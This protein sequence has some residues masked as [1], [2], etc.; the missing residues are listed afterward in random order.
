ML[1]KT[2]QPPGNLIK[3]GC[4]GGGGVWKKQGK[5]KRSGKPGNSKESGANMGEIMLEIH[6]SKTKAEMHEIVTW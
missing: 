4:W 5:E 3:V 1:S 2:F 6:T